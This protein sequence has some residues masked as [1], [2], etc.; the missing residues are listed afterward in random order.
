MAIHY[1]RSARLAAELLAGLPDSGHAVVQA[2]L[3]DPQ[4]VRRMVDESCAG[5]GA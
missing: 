3:A 1:G 4:V 5:L 2:D